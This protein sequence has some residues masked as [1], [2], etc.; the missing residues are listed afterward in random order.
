M[1]RIIVPLATAALLA[2]VAT[3]VVLAL[4]YEGEDFCQGSPAWPNGTYLGQM[5]PYHSDFYRGYAERRGW[6]PCTTWAT[7]QR[8][9]AIR[10]LRELGYT[11]VPPG[12]AVQTVSPPAAS[13]RGLTV[14]TEHRCAP[15]DADDYPYA[16]SLEPQIVAQQGGRIYGPYTGTWFAST[17]ETD[18][19]HIVAR[20][21]AHDSGLCAADA[22]RRQ[23]FASDLSNLTLASPAVNR[24][25]KSGKDAGEWS[26]DLNQCWFANQVLQ[27]RLAYGLTI[28]QAEAAALERVLS[29]CGSTEM[30]F[31]ARA[32]DDS[33]HDT[34]AR[35][36]SCV[37]ILRG[38]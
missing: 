13:W 33:D 37:R 34:N 19:E 29:G 12:E 1:R 36:R 32:G 35:S 26:P 28:D 23:A 6:D 20:S 5:H 7:D 4:N 9:S 31:T 2:V 30:V 10:G 17:T 8:N 22:D 24:Q 15:Y 11:V 21:E 38:S 14:S 27:V 25:Q 18:I 16:Q 3:G